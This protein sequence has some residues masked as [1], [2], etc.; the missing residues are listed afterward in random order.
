MIRFILGL[1]IAFGAAGG[2]ENSTDDTDLMLAVFAAIIGL[3]IMSAGA[4]KLQK[5]AK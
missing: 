4:N 5:E 3:A 2:V 1:L